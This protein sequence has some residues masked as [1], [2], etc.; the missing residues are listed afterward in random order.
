MNSQSIHYRLIAWYAGVLLIVLIGFGAFTY[1]AFRI[2]STQVL[3]ETLA[4]RTHQI[5]D[6][7]A[8]EAE[9]QDRSLPVSA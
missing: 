2:F 5:A 9:A 1:T 6:L 8:G 4:H 7:V 3:R